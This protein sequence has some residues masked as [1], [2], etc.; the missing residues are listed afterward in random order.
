LPF[1]PLILEI[2]RKRQNGRRRAVRK[3]PGPEGFGAARNSARALPKHAKQVECELR[4]VAGPLPI[5][6]IEDII[7]PGSEWEDPT[8]LI[9]KP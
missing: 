2:R 8:P 7:A 9:T 3:P 6:A 5:A 1:L 4:I